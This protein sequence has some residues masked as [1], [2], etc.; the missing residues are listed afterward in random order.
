M[1]KAGASFAVELVFI[2]VHSWLAREKY[3]TVSHFSYTLPFNGL[4]PAC[5]SFVPHP[6]SCRVGAFCED[7]SALEKPYGK[8]FIMDMIEVKTQNE[9]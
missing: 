8:F 7:G 3:E 9:P 5:P 1:K 6:E 4:K 2:R